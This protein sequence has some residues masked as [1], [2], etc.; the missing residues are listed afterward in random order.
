MQYVKVRTNNLGG[1]KGSD[2]CYAFTY[3]DGNGNLKT[4]DDFQHYEYG[5][6]KVCIGDTNKYVVDTYGETIQY[7]Y[8]TR[9]TLQSISGSF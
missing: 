1:V 9:D 4:I 6:T 3:I 2:L 8:L 7:L 5:L